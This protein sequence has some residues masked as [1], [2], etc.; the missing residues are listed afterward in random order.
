MRLLGDTLL[1]ALARIA[2]LGSAAALSVLTARLLGP[3]G[4]GAYALPS[5]DAGL[6]ATFVLGLGSAV[7]YFL[8]NGRAGRGVLRA[9]LAGGALATLAGGALTVAI[10]AWNHHL[11]AAIPALVYLPSYALLSLVSGYCVGR[12]RL[13]HWS[14]VN[15][16][17]SLV[18]L[19]L[20]AGVSPSSAA[21]RQSASPRGSR[22]RRSS[23]SS[24][25]SPSS[26][27]RARC[28]TTRPVSAHSYATRRRR[29]R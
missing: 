5:I 12:D 8:L 26:C 21:R 13:R 1:M 14:V 4:R 19:A 6:A 7:S 15:V 10:A 28:R 17:T 23:R 9:A 18:T 29:A 16:S 22:A 20:V 3:A 24:V 27:T 2:T 11:W 25:P